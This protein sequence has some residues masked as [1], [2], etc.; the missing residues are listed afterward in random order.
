VTLRRLIN[1]GIAALM[2]DLDDE[3]RRRMAKAL[4]GE[5]VPEIGREEAFMRARGARPR[6]GAPTPQPAGPPPMPAGY[7]LAP[8]GVQVRE[9]TPTY[10]L[11]HL[12]NA[13]QK[14]GRP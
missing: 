12:H 10:G 3:G 1:V 4:R 5:H 2:E 8:E 13:M 14:K 7:K 9:P 6:Q 11:E